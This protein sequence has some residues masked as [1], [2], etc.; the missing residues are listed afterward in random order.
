MNILILTGK[1][2]FGHTSAAISIKEKIKQEHPNYNVQ[3]I[4]FIEYLFPVISKGIYG[5]FNFLVNKC[6]ALY[7]FLNKIGS[8]NGSAPLKSFIVKKID[9]L[10]IE[11]NIDTVISVFPVCSQYI[12]A[13]K[14]MRKSNIV[15][16]TCI[17]DV[18]VHEEWI[19]DETNL[20]FVAVEM[21]KY[22][23]INM[24]V[25]SEKIVISGIPVKNSFNCNKDIN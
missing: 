16:N 17:T 22:N 21:T 11:N 14:K 19:S 1:F 12:S 3:I 6:C 13:Y 23:L 2:G 15:L 25:D 8:K 9:R 10:L 24:G 5:T 20:Y 7:N 4:D 18:D